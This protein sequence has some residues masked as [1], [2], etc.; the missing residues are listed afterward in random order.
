[1]TY[2]PAITTEETHLYDL[3]D[4]L[5]RA[6]S[7]LRRMMS[8][9]D[10]A[11]TMPGRTPDVDPDGTGRRATSGPSRPTERT[12]LD[13]DR[14]RLAAQVKNGIPHI[15]SATAHVRGVVAAMD[16]A[17]AVWE[18]EEHEAGETL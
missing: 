16:R 14:T 6:V 12:A 3:I 4:A 1:M 7:D 11:L 13:D 15:A 9:Y 10:D 18:G 8:I 5:D 2:S 17:L